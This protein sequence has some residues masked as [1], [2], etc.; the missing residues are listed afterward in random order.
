MKVEEKN[1]TI[2]FT[3]RNKEKI[4]FKIDSDRDAFIKKVQ[5][6]DGASKREKSEILDYIEMKKREGYVCPKCDGKV[7]VKSGKKM[8][9][10]GPIQQ[11][12]CKTCGYVCTENKFQQ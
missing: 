8:K 11:Y 1:H 5:T 12:L 9:K 7:M 6:H 2:I 10:G 3:L 4:K